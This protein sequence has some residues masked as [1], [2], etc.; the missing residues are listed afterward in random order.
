MELACELCPVAFFSGL[1]SLGLLR[2]LLVR[3]CSEKKLAFHK[4]A[5]RVFMIISLESMDGFPG[6]CDFL[7][8]IRKI[9]CG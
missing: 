1:C 2:T 3:M 5:A 4:E 6:F 8:I 9:V 7:D